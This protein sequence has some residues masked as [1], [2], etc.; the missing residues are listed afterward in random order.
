MVGGPSSI[1]RAIAPRGFD[2]SATTKLGRQVLIDLA[3]RF[4]SK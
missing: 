1:P 2:M 4:G 3:T